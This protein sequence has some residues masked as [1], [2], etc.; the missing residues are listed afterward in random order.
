MQKQLR[1]LTLNSFLLLG[2]ISYGQVTYYDAN[3]DYSTTLNPVTG[4]ADNLFPID[5]NNDGVKDFYFRW[6][7]MV[8]GSHE[9]WFVHFCANPVANPSRQFMLIPGNYHNPLVYS[10]PINASATWS[11]N[12][13]PAIDDSFVNRFQGLGD[14]YLAFKAVISGTTYY[15]WVLIGFVNKTLTIKE[16]AYTANAAGLTAGQGGSL[17]LTENSIGQVVLS[18]NPV[19]NILV[20]DNKD[21]AQQLFSYQILDMAG[22]TISEGKSSY[23][24][25]ITTDNIPCGNYI[26]RI[27][28][29]GITFTK[30]FI[31]L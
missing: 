29:D 12:W 18:P 24:R 3:P 6:D 5:L 4:S 27:E 13:D 23:G 14:R 21:K 17:G 19:D 11:S 26:I 1:L 9:D 25:A 2:S 28:N 15:G 31:K 10:T 8:F 20:I 7:D 22:K 16:Y 30:K